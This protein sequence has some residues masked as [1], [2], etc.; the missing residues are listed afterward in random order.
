MVHQPG[1]VYLSATTGCG[2]A[3]KNR[4]KLPRAFTKAPLA[5]GEHRFR[6]NGDLLSVR[7]NDKKEIYFLSTIHKANM[8]NTGRCDC[9]GNQIRKLQ[10]IHDYNC[11]M[12]G[13]DWNNKMTAN[14]NSLRKSMKWTKKVAFHF[15][16]EAVLNSFYLKGNLT[17]EGAPWNSRWRQFHH[18]LLQLVQ[19]LL[20]LLLQPIAC[21]DA[22]SL[23]LF[24]QLY[25][26]NTIPEGV[27][28]THK[29]KGEKRADINEGNALRS[30]DSVL[31]LVFCT[32]PDLSSP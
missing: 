13:V 7:F 17:S 23:N 16:E 3:R 4:I 19:M 20:L 14:Y 6:R 26:W 15:I 30:Q 27:W 21:Q 18:F 10:V 5:K 1:I 28:F 32:Q 29:T 25:P 12:G 8:V 31:H 2:T 9:Q 22:I 11:Y 24:L